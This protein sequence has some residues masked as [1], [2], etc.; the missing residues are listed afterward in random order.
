M[1]VWDSLLLSQFMNHTAGIDLCILVFADCVLNEE[2][3]SMKCT[4]HKVWIV[5]SF[6]NTLMF[7][8]VSPCMS[9]LMHLCVPRFMNTPNFCNKCGLDIDI[10]PTIL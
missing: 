7:F 5:G 8:S 1:H 2:N 6:T 9:F 3:F 10:S 4:K